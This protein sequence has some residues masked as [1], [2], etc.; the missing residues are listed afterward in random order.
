[1]S[2]KMVYL[3]EVVILGGPEEANFSQ[4][5]HDWNIYAIFIHPRFCLDMLPKTFRLQFNV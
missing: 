3:W 5:I 2:L 1:M 4:L